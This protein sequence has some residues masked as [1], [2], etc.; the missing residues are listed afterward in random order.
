MNKK[1]ILKS[2]NE[3][4]DHHFITEAL[5]NDLAS[6]ELEAEFLDGLLSDT[7]IIS[8]SNTERTFANT[9]MVAKSDLREIKREAPSNPTPTKPT[10]KTYTKDDVRKAGM[11]VVENIVNEDDAIASALAIAKLI[12][13]L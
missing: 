12:N 11:R 7:A 10:E 9:F 8:P 4:S 1:Y 2:Y 13:E 6:K 3:V 5:W